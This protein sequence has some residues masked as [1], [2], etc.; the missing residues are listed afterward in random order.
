MI[1]TYVTIAGAVWGIVEAYTYFEGEQL[2]LWLGGY[3]PWIFLGLPALIAIGV[4]LSA[5]WRE[6]EGD[7]TTSAQTAEQIQRNRAAM[8]QLVHNTWISGVFEQSLHGAAMLELG[9]DYTPDAV[10]R[11]WDV[12]LHLPGQERRPVPR[13]MSILDLFDEANGALLIL[14]EPGSGKTTTLLELA[15]ALIERAKRDATCHIPVVLNLSSWAVKQLPF[16]EWLIDELR[17]KYYTPKRVAQAWV[18][19][20]AL[21]L[22]LDGLDEVRADAR[23]KCLVAIHA[24]RQENFIPLAICSRMADYEM[25]TTKLHFQTAITLR[26]LTP[27]QIDTYL[28]GAGVELYAVRATLQHD[29]IL[30]EMAQSPLFLSIMTLAYRGKTIADL[31]TL[32][33]PEARRHHLFDTYVTRM[34]Q[35]RA[36]NA[37]YTPGQTRH[38][39]TWLAEQ[40]TARNQTVFLIEDLQPDWLPV[41]EQHLVRVLV[42]LFVSL[43]VGFFVTQIISPFFLWIGGLSVGLSEWFSSLLPPKVSRWSWHRAMIGFGIGLMAGLTLGLVEGLIYGLE[44]GLLSGLTNGLIIGSIV[45]LVEGAIGGID[46]VICV[47]TLKW[48]WRNAAIGFGIGLIFGS[49]FGLGGVLLVVVMDDIVDV[50]P[51]RIL[52]SQLVFGLVFGLVT[53]LVGG[54]HSADM[55]SKT[56][57]NEGIKQ[58]VRNAIVLG[59]GG[60][61]V[62][63][64]ILGLMGQLN[65]GLSEGLI[66]WL[67]FGLSIGLVIGLTQGGK[68]AILHYTLRAILTRIGHTPWHY[69]RFLDVCTDLVLLRKVSGGYIFIH[70]LLQEYFASP[71][72]SAIVHEL[73]SHE[74]ALSTH[75][76]LN[77]K[78]AASISPCRIIFV[79]L[80]T[81]LVCVSGIATWK[82]L[83]RSGLVDVYLRLENYDKALELDPDNGYIYFTRAWDL[84]CGQ[85][86]ES[87]LADLRKA[88]ELFK[89]DEYYWNTLCWYGSI[90]GYAAEVIDACEKAVS[91]APDDGGIIDSR[92]LALALTGDYETAVEDF[93]F[94][95][96]WAE[97]PTFSVSDEDIALR[98]VWIASLEAGRNPFDDATLQ[99][100]RDEACP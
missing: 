47:E 45:G 28:A 31:Q 85:D 4:G 69:G 1:I 71:E 18:Q 23:D 27:D 34:F 59:P 50:T 62:V 10:E 79:L 86:Y 33:T 43:V 6:R 40:M 54:F 73:A 82:L 56:R 93:R 38:W 78:A 19:E 25:L 15:L 64:L 58:S 52:L 61:L 22:L 84:Y 30:Q 87:A 66:G 95:I 51:L 3:W 67:A 94:Y 17:T 16:E 11:P 97:N 91:L 24:F 46:T 35:R 7:A 48:S 2:R 55:Q 8:L 81:C 36:K 26:P 68:A 65:S 76:S 77:G 9:K 72:Q 14:G 96:Q 80:F 20:D 39:L 29:P 37:S 21:L 13:G 92:G 60:G 42:I 49:I 89:D 99:A 44:T 12:E 74:R 83:D 57:P 75:F 90:S 88:A 5:N 41:R 32:A 98:K 63:G 53:G 70:R 100:L